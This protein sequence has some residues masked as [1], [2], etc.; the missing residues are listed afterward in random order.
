VISGSYV[1]AA[2]SFAAARRVF[3]ELTLAQDDA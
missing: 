1:S 2:C 3:R